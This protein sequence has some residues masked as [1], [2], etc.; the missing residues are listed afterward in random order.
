MVGQRCVFIKLLAN[1]PI[2]WKT[3]KNKHPQ[4]KCMLLKLK[5]LWD[6]ELSKTSGVSTVPQNARES[7]SLQASEIELYE[8]MFWPRKTVYAVAQIVTEHG[9]TSCSC[10]RAIFFCLS[11]FIFS[12]VIHRSHSLD[13]S[14]WPFQLLCGKFDAPDS[15]EHISCDV[16]MMLQVLHLRQDCR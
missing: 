14:D 15:L 4:I 3:N 6:V 7:Q 5:K 13:C 12:F 1:L 10:H 11:K 16:Q 9:E 2:A 8:N